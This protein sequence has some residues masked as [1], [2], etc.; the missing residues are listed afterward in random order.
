LDLIFGNKQSDDEDCPSMGPEA[1]VDMNT[2][3]R[4]NEAYK[5]GSKK[6]PAIDAYYFRLSDHNLYYT[7]DAD[8]MVVLGAIAIDS[9]EIT[10]HSEADL[11]KCF[12]VENA[13]NDEWV[14]CALTTKEKK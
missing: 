2:V 7:Q 11:N 4:V 14:L 9:I 5:K 10:N 3:F 8:S 6:I 12:E 13:E 1:A